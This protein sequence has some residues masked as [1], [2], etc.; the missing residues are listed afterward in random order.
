MRSQMSR[1]GV[2]IRQLV[3]QSTKQRAATP[4]SGPKP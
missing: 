3:E 1:V 4:E 2:L